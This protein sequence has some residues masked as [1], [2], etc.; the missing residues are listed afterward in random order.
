MLNTGYSVQEIIE[1]FKTYVPV[2]ERIARKFKEY[3]ELTEKLKNG[4]ENIFI[5]LVQSQQYVS[6]D[7]SASEKMRMLKDIMAGQNLS[8]KVNLTFGIMAGKI[9]II[10]LTSSFKDFLDLMKTQFGDKTREEMEAMLKSGM[11][12]EQV[13]LSVVY[14]ISKRKRSK[15]NQTDVEMSWPCQN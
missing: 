4:K 15:N 5:V 9:W 12:M 7:V 14:L 11:S 3:K 2:K 13:G 1:Y 6:G 8:E 10:A